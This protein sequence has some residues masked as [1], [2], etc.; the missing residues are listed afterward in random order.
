[1]AQ[2]LVVDPKKCKACRTC[3]LACS[4]GHHDEFNPR[5]A[6]VTVFNFEEDA[7]TVPVMCMQCEE[8]ACAAVCPTGALSI[9]ADGVVSHNADKCLVCK[10]CVSACPLGNI[11]FS[12]ATKKV[13]KCDLCEGDPMCAKFCPT[14]AISVMDPATA[15]AKKKEAAD[16]I[17]STVEEA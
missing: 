13:F 3:E 5:L 14:G 15:P 4:F 12:P 7:I 6:C 8:P 10:L 1:M 2:Q 16:K 9:N 17:K 11:S